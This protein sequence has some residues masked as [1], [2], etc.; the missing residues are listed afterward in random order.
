MEDYGGAWCAEREHCHRF[1][2]T[3]GD[4][5]RLTN[6]PDLPNGSAALTCNLYSGDPW[7]YCGTTPVGSAGGQQNVTGDGV[8]DAPASSQ[9]L[10]QTAEGITDTFSLSIVAQ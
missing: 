9:E 4:D 1:V 7:T 3:S 5:G 6:C 2:H 8:G 10:P